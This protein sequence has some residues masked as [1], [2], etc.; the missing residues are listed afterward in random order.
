MGVCYEH[1]IVLK[2]ILNVC[3]YCLLD[4]GRTLQED[5]VFLF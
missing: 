5:L 3:M 1:M 4:T 2:A